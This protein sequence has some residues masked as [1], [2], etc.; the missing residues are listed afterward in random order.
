MFT[1][2][3]L[4][5]HVTAFDSTCRTGEIK[6]PDT[7]ESLLQERYRLKKWNKEALIVYLVA[8]NVGLE[9]MLKHKK[10]NRGDKDSPTETSLTE[11][12]FTFWTNHPDII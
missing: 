1:E 7:P 5:E 10:V 8:H 4:A 2:E 9:G 12:L 11:I 3:K 6:F